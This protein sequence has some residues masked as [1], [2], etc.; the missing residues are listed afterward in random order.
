MQRREAKKTVASKEMQE[1]KFVEDNLFAIHSHVLETFNR[2]TCRTLQEHGDPY[3]QLWGCIVELEYMW[4]WNFVG[5]LACYCSKGRPTCISSLS[6]V[7]LQANRSL[8]GWDCAHHPTGLL[9]R[10]HHAT[11][12]SVV[13][14][15][16]PRQFKLFLS[17]AGSCDSLCR[18]G[19]VKICLCDFYTSFRPLIDCS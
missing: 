8:I 12:L 19:N 10:W 2:S 13:G 4:F 5:Y 3:W 15:K 7:C 1:L 14:Q 18:F 9:Q 11:E 16:I 6:I 17:S